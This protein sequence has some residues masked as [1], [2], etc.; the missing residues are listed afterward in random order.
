MLKILLLATL[1]ILAGQEAHA[2]IV[3]LNA[4]DLIPKIELSF[5]PRTGS[6]TEGSTFDIPILINTKGVSVN[7]VEIRINFDKDRLEIVK[8]SSGQS[9]I[10][11]WVE[12]PSY[13]NTRGFANYVGIIPSGITTSSGSIG[14]IT[15]RA[16]KTGRAT[17]SFAASS[18]VLLNDGFGTE[19][20]LL[21]GRSEYTII[22][23]A[24]EGVRVAS[25]THP[26]SS[27]W[28]NNNSPILFWD[29][30]PGVTGFSYILDDKPT[31]IPEN[32]IIGNETI[33]AFENLED[34]L[35]YFHVKANRNG[36]WG[37]PGHFLVRIDTT[38]PADFTPEVDYLLAAAIF[39]ERALVSFFTT[40]NLSGI[41]HY[42]VGVIDQ[43]QP[44]TVSPVFVQ[45]ESPY[46]VSLTS[47]KLSVL[48][49]A[50]DKAGNIRD[51][52][53]LVGPP[54]LIG[55]FIKDNL[56]YILLAIILAGLI[57]LT[58]HY[59]VG[60]HIIRYLRKASEL[61]KKEEQQTST[62][63]PYIAQKPNEITGNYPE[64]RQK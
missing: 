41:D 39:T 24:P 2:Q 6:F 32:T 45:T 11:V 59:L 49:R 35:W 61:V 37:A 30:D 9:I 56:V 18:K 14:S 55:K 16:K 8:P 46:Q 50:V 26:F 53:I 20:T 52:S 15:F 1:T 40:D 31:T 27:E 43:N 21:L 47:D 64:S 34:G 38:P 63:G 19:A 58:F 22:S 62:P 60:H 28:Y 4:S 42:E 44:V 33:K 36:A 13:D 51:V 10:G 25:E 12:P 54:S 17:L 48:V 7:G 29:K 57:G 5:S 3:N 23:K